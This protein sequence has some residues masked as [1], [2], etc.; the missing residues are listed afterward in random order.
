MRSFFVLL[1]GIVAMQAAFATD[2]RNGETSSR[3]LNKRSI[4]ISVVENANSIRILDDPKLEARL[5]RAWFPGNDHP[6]D[7]ATIA[8]RLDKE[9]NPVNVKVVKSSN[10]SIFDNG[11]VK[12]I[13]RVAP[14]TDSNLVTGSNMEFRVDFSI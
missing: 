12:A 8:F 6:K 14:I 2:S 1:I 13:N 3:H 11:A 7:G 10:S 5:R 4:S 9:G